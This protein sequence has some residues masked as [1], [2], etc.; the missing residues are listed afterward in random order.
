MIERWMSLATYEKICYC[1]M[2]AILI[3][4]FCFI[5]YMIHTYRADMKKLKEGE[6]DWKKFAE[7]L[8]SLD[9]N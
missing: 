5:I 7:Q 4:S 2:F 1:F 3:A 6:E 9:K 8:N